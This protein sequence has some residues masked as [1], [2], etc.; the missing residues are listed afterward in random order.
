VTPDATDGKPTW[1]AV[2]NFLIEVGPPKKLHD[3]TTTILAADLHLL[4]LD[5]KEYPEGDAGSTTTA[6]R[7]EK[8]FDLV[9][10]S[11]EGEKASTVEADAQTLGSITSLVLFLQ[12]CP[13]EPATYEVHAL[14]EEKGEIHAG[15]VEVKGAGKFTEGE[16]TLETWM[17]TGKIG[18]HGFEIYFDA[19]DRSFLAIRMDSGILI[20]KAGILKAAAPL[21]PAAN[22]TECGARLALA[23][24]T[25]DEDLLASAI[26]WPS[27]L[28]DAKAAKTFEGDEAE[29]KKEI[30][31]GF[32]A[33]FKKLTHAD[34]VARVK[35]AA[36]GAKETVTGDVT[37][38]TFGAPMDK[39]SYSA[40]LID[41]AWYI[42]KFG[43]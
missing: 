16:T 13:V 38:V 41:G 9:K 6:V 8:G 18:E 29:F 25:S 34:A 22:A 7:T 12:N 31:G 39:F 40:K 15:A 17:A 27:M 10:K 11:A 28:A 19:A 3:E 37:V 43:G 33:T 24:L 36:D 20:S 5:K 42:V 23:I 21:P 1:K 35:G 26:H 14:S 30:M 2:E 4:R 32:R